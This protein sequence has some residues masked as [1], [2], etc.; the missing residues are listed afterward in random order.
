MGSKIIKHYIPSYNP[1]WEKI[2]NHYEQSAKPVIYYD[3]ET[4]KFK[5][6]WRDRFISQSS[7]ASKQS[8][9]LLHVEIGCNKGHVIRE[10]AKQNPKD[11]YIGIDWKMKMI[12]HGFEKSVIDQQENLLLFRAH[13]D[14][15]DH[16]FAPEEIDRLYIYFP[17]PWAKKS[18]LK[19]RFISEKTLALIHP[20][21]SSTGVVHIKTDH[22]E[23]FE[24]VLHSL[25]K[26]ETLWESFELTYDL[27][28][29][30]PHPELLK[31]PEVTLFE[32]LFI[33]DGIKIKS[34]KLRKRHQL[35]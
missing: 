35:T 8:Q 30:H 13:A 10:W 22:D 12:Y 14:R 11:L 7:P 15:I 9:R 32:K 24:W 1:Y 21:L 23:Y 33:K 6:Q 3:Y 26:V 25:K 16:M 31:I 27:H 28:A 29:G 5:G 2:K 34:I 18:Q 4:E 19:N 17:D 20:L